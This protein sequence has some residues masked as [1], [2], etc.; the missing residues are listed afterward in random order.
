MC[1]RQSEG[2]WEEEEKEGR[3]ERGQGAGKERESKG[4]RKRG[5]RDRVQRAEGEE[6]GVEG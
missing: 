5:W 4:R 2:T 3:K 6:D 1:V